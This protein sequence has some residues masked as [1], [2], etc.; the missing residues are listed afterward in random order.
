MRQLILLAV[1]IVGAVASEPGETPI[2]EPGA[3]DAAQPSPMR[4]LF[5]GNSLSAA[6]GLPRMLEA[7]AAAGG[8]TVMETAAVT[9]NDFSLEDHWNAGPARHTIARR[10]WDVVVLQQGPSALPESQVLLREYVTRFDTIV[11]IAGAK[12]ALYMVW[13][14]RARYSDM[15]GVIASYSNASRSVMGTLLPAGLAWRMALQRDP[16][17]PLYS[18]DGFHPSAIGSYLAALVIYEGLT[19]H[20]TAGQP[21]VLSDPTLTADRLHL[22]QDVAHHAVTQGG[23]EE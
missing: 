18:Q 4:V 20:A 13:P 10:G 17:I 15:D 12:T 6:N 16:D 11:R 7:I 9:A 19:A 5:I 2:P 8:R 21:R 14:S 23:R 3:P 22:L 1:L